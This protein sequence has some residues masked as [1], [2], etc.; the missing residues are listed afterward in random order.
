MVPGVLVLDLGGGSAAVQHAPKIPIP[1]QTHDVEA[2]LP[3]EHALGQHGREDNHE[4]HEGF[5]PLILPRPPQAVEES[6][7]EQEQTQGS[8]R[9]QSL[10][11]LV[12]AVE[13]VD[14]TGFQTISSIDFVQFGLEIAC[15]G[16]K[17]GVLAVTFQGILPLGYAK[18]SSSPTVGGMVGLKVHH[19]ANP[20][21]VHAVGLNE[22]PRQEDYD[23]Q[24]Y[25]HPPSKFPK[26][27]KDEQEDAY[28]RKAGEHGHS[29][30]ELGDHHHREEHIGDVSTIGPWCWLGGRQVPDRGCQNPVL[31]IGDQGEQDPHAEVDRVQTA[32]ACQ[33]LVHH[34]LEPGRRTTAAQEDIA[35][36]KHGNKDRAH[37]NAASKP[38]VLFRQPRLQGHEGQGPNKPL[39]LAEYLSDSFALVIAPAQRGQG[40]NP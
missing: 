23:G 1:Q 27:D 8:K 4:D 25:S 22:Q 30:G 36:T 5:P 11:V 24:A 12:M 21:T 9:S 28:H 16:S 37:P 13:L 20:G 33:I 29:G 18:G 2:F 3:F 32:G 6:Q 35:H 38:S 40:P 26:S 14:V 10:Q 19:F 39:G 15:A 31:G 17:D 34:V 7:Q